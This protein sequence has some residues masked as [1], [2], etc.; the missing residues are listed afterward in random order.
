MHIKAVPNGS[1]AALVLALLVLAAIVT[2]VAES[3]AK[4]AIPKRLTGTWERNNGG[5]VLMEVG[6]R[7]KVSVG[8]SWSVRYH[9]KFSHVTAHRL[10][11][12]GIPSCSGTGT[13]RWNLPGDLSG[14]PSPLTIKKIH[15]ACKPRVDLFEASDWQRP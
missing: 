5:K 13:Y 1:R 3:A 7:G 10:S 8:R 9:T 4:T 2:G 12:S 14:G 15:D 6:S 11:I